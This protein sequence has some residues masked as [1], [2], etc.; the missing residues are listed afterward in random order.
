V[1]LARLV[2]LPPP[3]HDPEHVRRTAREILSRPQYQWDHPPNLLQRLAD[4][5][6]R[7]L[8]RIG[9][10]IGLPTLPTWVG[11]LVLALV[12]G[13]LVAA[14]WLSRARWAGAGRRP[15]RGGGGKDVVVEAGEEATDW[16]AEVERCEAEGR[17]RDG[18]RARYRGLVGE[19]AGR[20][21]LPDLV[22]RTAGELAA[23]LRRR[24]AAAA[25][26]FDAAT[27][28]F[29]QVWYGGAPC[30]P[31]ERDRF[32]GWATAVRD[33]APAAAPEAAAAEAVT[34]TVGAP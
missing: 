33:R 28:L 12:A 2:D 23:D 14:I 24:A 6:A 29:E 16:A 8:S 5:I 1:A 26:A 32:A 31:A 22:G 25:P 15:R 13:L 3:T 34:V 21:V 19:L 10:P 30:G 7:Q 18:L 11:W 17:W 20:G 9:A 27:G 4:W